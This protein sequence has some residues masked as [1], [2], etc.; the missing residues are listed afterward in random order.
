MSKFEKFVVKSGNNQFGDNNIQN[1]ITNNTINNKARES[2]D[3]SGAIFG[4]ITGIAGVIWFFFNHINQIYHY[5]NIVILSS[6]LFSIGAFF[7]LLLTRSVFKTDIFRVM[8]SILV[9]I[10]LYGLALLARSHAPNEIIQ[11]AHQAPSLMEFWKQLTDIGRK[12]VVENFISAVFIC[13]ASFLALL[14]S[15]RQFAYSIANSN[16]T[17]WWYNIYE[18]MSYFNMRSTV[19]IIVTLSGAV[20]ALLNDKIPFSF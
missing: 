15:F 9:A 7:I 16:R 1:N 6:L 11:L 5:L 13:I 10:S 4:F 18:S 12:I 14:G 2:T 17:G 8:A 20:W 19:I 3:S